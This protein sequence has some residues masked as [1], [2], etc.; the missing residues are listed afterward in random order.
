MDAI[1]HVK[2][3]GTGTGLVSPFEMGVAV[4]VVGTIAALP[5]IRIIFLACTSFACPVRCRHAI[6]C[7]GFRGLAKVLTLSLHA[8]KPV[9]IVYICIYM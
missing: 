6:C 2:T 5:E 8:S 1:S 3:D 4:G 7:C 9:I